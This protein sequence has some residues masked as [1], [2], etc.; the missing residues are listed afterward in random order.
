MTEKQ[1]PRT[2]K[3]N[4]ALHV[5]FSK[6]SD[7]LNDAGYDVMK[8]LRHD[9]AIP[10]QPVLIKELMWRQIQKAM[11]DKQSTADLSSGEL[12]LVYDTLNRHLGE[13]FGIH[14]PWPSIEALVEEDR[15]MRSYEYPEN[16]LDP[17]F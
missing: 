15:R 1:K 3:Q 7:M 10:W 4:A 14:C 12:Q 6:L 8:T 16:D 5:F 17:K 2:I 13:R 11:Y 9:I